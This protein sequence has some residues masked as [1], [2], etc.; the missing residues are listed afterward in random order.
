MFP[1]PLSCRETRSLRLPLL[2]AREFAVWQGFRA[3][4]VDQGTIHVLMAGRNLWFYRRVTNGF[5][6]SLGKGSQI[7]DQGLFWASLG[8]FFSGN[9]SL[10]FL[11]N[12][13]W[14]NP[15]QRQWR[16]VSAT[17]QH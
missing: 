17:I 16:R 12:H 1:Q 4:Q 2:L 8:P 13:P 3:R 14:S 6:G 15:G 7:R 11:N 5:Q 10:V 9:T